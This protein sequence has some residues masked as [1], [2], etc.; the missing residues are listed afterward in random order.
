MSNNDRNLSGFEDFEHKASSG[1]VSRKEVYKTAISFLKMSLS[2]SQKKKVREIINRY[3]ADESDNNLK[4]IFEAII[5]EEDNILK[6]KPRRVLEILHSI[7]SRGEA[8]LKIPLDLYVYRGKQYLIN[9][10]TKKAI[11]LLKYV[12][13]VNNNTSVLEFLRIIYL[14]LC[15]K[16]ISEGKND[17]AAE[18]LSQYCEIDPNDTIVNHRLAV[19]ITL[20]TTQSRIESINASWNKIL[21]LW[22]IRYKQTGDKQFKDKILAKHK[23]FVAKFVELEKWDLAKEELSMILQLEPDNMVAKRAFVQI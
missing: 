2:S 16:N 3:I 22:H 17:H 19:L 10:E 13:K 7:S 4:E 12:H 20:Y 14:K 18:L 9:K 23:Y 21:K 5:K 6:L 11:E 15:D 1:N 8:D